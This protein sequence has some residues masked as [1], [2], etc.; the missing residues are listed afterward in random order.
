MKS[1][2]PLFCIGYDR[3]ICTLSRKQN[4]IPSG[5]VK[6]CV[7]VCVCFQEAYS[8]RQSKLNIYYIYTLYVCM[9][10]HTS[11]HVYTCG[12]LAYIWMYDVYKHDILIIISCCFLFLTSV[13]SKQKPG[14]DFSLPQ[15]FAKD[16]HHSCLFKL[17][18]HRWPWRNHGIHR[19]HK[20]GRDR[21]SLSCP[22]DEGRWG[23]VALD[24]GGGGW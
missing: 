16:V 17:L 15:N 18:A 19:S 14:T 2:V 12:I 22:F 8:L 4:Q 20:H 24:S 13:V 9:Y 1:H 7:C 10:V 23:K 6:V 21:A 5:S 11:I 3:N